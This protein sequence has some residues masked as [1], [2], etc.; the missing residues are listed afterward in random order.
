M[1]GRDLLS[2]DTFCK[3]GRHAWV[4]LHCGHALRLLQ[5]A[6]SKIPSTGSD[7]QDLICRSEIRLSSN[8]RLVTV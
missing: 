3:L 8:I 7:F 2:L 1:F 6:Y 4:H 5:D